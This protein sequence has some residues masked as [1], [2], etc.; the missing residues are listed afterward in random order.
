[1]FRRKDELDM[2]GEFSSEQGSLLQSDTDNTVKVLSPEKAA[3]YKAEKT[4]TESADKPAGQS[5]SFSSPSSYGQTA[6]PIQK[7]G[8][9]STELKPT[10]TKQ[11]SMTPSNSNQTNSYGANSAQSGAPR[12]TGADSSRFRTPVVPAEP[13]RPVA[14][15]VSTPSSFNSESGSMLN[16]HNQNERVLTVGNDILLKGEI[17]AC[18][19][20]VIEGNVDATVSEVTTMEL[21]SAGSFKGNAEVDYA[22]IS[23]EFVGNLVVRSSLVIHTTGRVNG[24]ITYG[25]IEIARGGVIT[26]EIKSIGN[27]SSNNE[28]KEEKVAA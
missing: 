23:G 15:P 27:T 26:G 14:S 19:R 4:N 22:E 16:K 8:A 21:T 11:A 5:A 13:S 9:N 3:E 10:Q 24:N 20:L 7:P 18:D 17:T 28:K 6:R 1:M 25:E 2:D 12:N